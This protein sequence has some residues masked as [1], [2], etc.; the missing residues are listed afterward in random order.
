MNIVPHT[1]D[2][3]WANLEQ[4]LLPTRALSGARKLSFEDY[5]ASVSSSL[6]WQSNCRVW[7]SKGGYTDAT[8]PVN[9]VVPA[10]SRRNK[11]YGPQYLV[12]GTSIAWLWRRQSLV[13]NNN[14]ERTL[15]Q[16][17][18]CLCPSKLSV[19]IKCRAVD[20][21]SKFDGTV[22]INRAFHGSRHVR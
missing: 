21:Q 4:P 17:S 14:T 9:F 3:P 12:F 20:I 13:K 19:P 10:L 11:N 15:T 16:G 7:Q 1:V 5:T 8:P 18:A 22:R 2:P 6:L